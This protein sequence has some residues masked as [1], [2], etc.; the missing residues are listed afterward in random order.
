MD[1]IGTHSWGV[2]HKW[3]FVF[4]L[5]EWHCLIQEIVNFYKNRGFCDATKSV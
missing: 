4:N 5:N 3:L 1:S 2:G